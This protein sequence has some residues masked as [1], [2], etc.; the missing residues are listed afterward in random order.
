MC[1]L[2]RPAG[3]DKQRKVGYFFVMHKKRLLPFLL[4]FLAAAPGWAAEPAAE[5]RA[6]RN[7][8]TVTVIPY[9]A[10]EKLWAKFAPFVEYLKEATGHPWELKLY[11]NHA[12]LI[13]GLC[14]GEVTFALLGPV[15][16]G[17]VIDK[18][19]AGVE[20]V[21]LGRDGKPFYRSVILTGDRTITSLA[22]LRGK[23]FGV[24]KGSTAAHIVPLKLLKDAG[25]AE[26][27]VLRVVYESQDRIMHELLSGEIAAAGVKDTLFLKFRNEPL[28]VLSTSSPLPG[29]AFASAPGSR[30]ALRKAFVEAL[31][32]LAP[33]RSEKDRLRMA[34]W[35]DE[36][37]NG[38]IAPP[39]DFRSSVQN[40]LAAYN[41][42]AREDK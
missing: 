29:F 4:L 11:H 25:V 24:F 31:L 5:T 37:K 35:D 15:P 7:P 6:V 28:R 23:K 14:K 26:A 21:A 16:L 18:C 22:M 34:D 17:R 30:A 1:G 27:E 39:P 8:Y 13:D 3:L 41:E 12:S 20:A 40:V 38:F 10:P 42:I 2:F 33:R 32:A 36:I 19:K 9:Y